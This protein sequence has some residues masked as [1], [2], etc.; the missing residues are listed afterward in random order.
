M[1]MNPLLSKYI[2]HIFSQTVL[3][4]HSSSANFILMQSKLPFFKLCSLKDRSCE[5][6]LWMCFAKL[7]VMLGGVVILNSFYLLIRD[8]PFMAV[9]TFPQ[10]TL[11]FWAFRLSGWGIPCLFHANRHRYWGRLRLL[12]CALSVPFQG[13]QSEGA[14]SRRLSQGT[15][16]VL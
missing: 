7:R 1:T 6:R 3:P 5:I 8:K 4:F 10:T 12:L 2:V 14:G 9:G 15:Q 16:H 11:P 13:T